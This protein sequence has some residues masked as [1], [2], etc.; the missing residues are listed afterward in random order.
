MESETRERNAARFFRISATERT[1]EEE[2]GGV[3]EEGVEKEN[4]EGFRGD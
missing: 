2:E 4:E 1:L 3:N